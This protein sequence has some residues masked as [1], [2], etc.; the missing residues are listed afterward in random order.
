MYE[1]MHVHSTFSDGKGSLEE[2]IEAAKAQGLIRLGCVDHVRRD[3]DWL[4]SFVAAI[5]EAQR[6]TEIELVSAVETK[7]LNA[8]G[9]LDLPVD[10][11]GIQRIYIADHQIPL[12][13]DCVPPSMIRR[14]VMEGRETA[15]RAV[16]RTLIATG[17]ALEA[18]PGSVIA[19]FLSIANKI[20]IAEEDVPLEWIEDLAEI[21]AQTG[22]AIELSERWR[23]PGARTLKP[24]V[25]RGVQ[26]FWSTDSH[27]PDRIGKYEF[28]PE[29]ISELR[30][31]STPP[32]HSSPPSIPSPA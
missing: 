18:H 13:N 4:P 26:V 15:L 20:R 9:D 19:H 6:G 32:L 25:A 5:E 2:N 12:G 23:C 16:H 8:N 7:I 17:R 27:R 10:L 11:G 31:M 14:M 3:T 29:V 22:S 1:D 21:T 30:S 28:V 24:F